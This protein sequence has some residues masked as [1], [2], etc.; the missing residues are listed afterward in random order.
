FLQK[1]DAFYQNQSFWS[2]KPMVHILPHWNVDFYDGEP[3]TVRV[4]TNCDEAELFLNGKSLG[5]KAVTPYTHLQW[6]VPAERGRLEAVG[7][8][9]GREAARDVTETTGAPVELKLRLENKAETADDVA[10]ITCYAVDAEGRF[11]PDAQPVVEFATN[12]LGRIL[13]TGSDISD[14]TPLGSPVRKMRAGLISVAVGA[15]VLKGIP[16]SREGIIEVYARAEGLAPA[17]LCYE[18]KDNL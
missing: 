6:Q 18:I 13:S 11:V 12:P 17:R 14:H 8:R 4:Y 2:K 5:R 1:K 10:V 15:A 16:A 9:V 7:Y 3:V